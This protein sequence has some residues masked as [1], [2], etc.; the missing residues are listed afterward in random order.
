[1]RSMAYIR[2]SAPTVSREAPAL[3]RLSFAAPSQPGPY[4]LFVEVHDGQGHAAYAN[5]PFHVGEP[6][7]QAD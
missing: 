6:P 2:I 7:V 5:F 1:M 4:R 3:P